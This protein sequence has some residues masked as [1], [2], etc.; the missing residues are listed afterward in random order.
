MIMKGDCNVLYLDC[1]QSNLDSFT[2]D[3]KSTFKIHTV[4]SERQGLKVLESNNINVIISDLKPNDCSS[5]DFL[6]KVK[7]KHPSIKFILLSAVID[8]D[9]ITEA[10]NN[11][12]IYRFLNKPCDN[13]KLE[14]AIKSA[15]ESFHIENKKNARNEKFELILTTAYDA[16]ITINDEQIIEDVNPAALKMFEYNQE[17]LLGKNLGILIPTSVQNH[18]QLINKFGHSKSKSR[19]MA[20]GNI[21]YGKAKSGKL[22]AIETNLSKIIQ[23]GKI[24]YN[25]I[26]RDVSEK[27]K[28]EE[29][30]KDSKDTLERIFNLSAYMVGIYSPDGI[31]QKVSPAFTETL[32]FSEKEFLS[33]PFI[34]FV[35]PDDKKATIDNMEPLAR[36]IPIIR[37]PNRYICKDGSYKWLEWTARS[38]VTGGKIYVMAYDITYRKKTE[39]KLKDSEGKFK[40]VFN[41]MVDVFV[42][43]DFDGNILLVSPSVYDVTGYDPKEIIKNKIFTYFVNKDA[44]KPLVQKLLQENDTQTFEAEIIKKDGSIIT[45]SSRS[46]LFFDAKGKALGV[47]SVFR[48]ISAQRK[49]VNTILNYQQRLKDLTI[50][51]TL[52]E[53]KLR[54]EIA[55]DLHDDVG[56]LLSASRM[57]IAT[58][59]YKADIHEIKSKVN[60]IS[61]GLIEAIR[62]TKKAIF[63]LS[64]PQL[65]EIGLYAAIDSFMKDEVEAKFPIQ[66]SIR[67]IKDSYAIAEEFRILLFRCVRE[68]TNN[69]IK[70]AN[71]KHIDIE[72]KE[73]K[74]TFSIIVVDDGVGFEYDNFQNRIGSKGYGLFSIEERLSNI[75]GSLDVNSILGQGTEIIMTV[76]LK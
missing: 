28:T 67:S 75:G 36:G 24:F 17:E 48:D 59:D 5:I 43:R 65:H 25:A 3:F 73:A 63:N 39:K 10:I 32:G 68:L 6:K 71:A 27:I 42:R 51:L 38:F 1:V 66:T 21:I 37:F 23:D 50:E 74:R 53:E 61:Q 64:P 30:L 54:K 14:H 26:I 41:S 58:I 46:K 55:I 76:P 9:I 70:H 31:F 56:Q 49:H 19:Q 7:I 16:I 8:L 40:G 57:Q 52:A 18:G 60:N 2:S 45:I 13:K 11:V 44:V 20:S 15:C 22:I 33:Q 4:I 29:V 34:N 12:G 72:L 47:E 69:V 35:H 62:S